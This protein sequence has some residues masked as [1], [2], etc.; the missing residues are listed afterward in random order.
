MPALD[1]AVEKQ[2]A[3]DLKLCQIRHTKGAKSAAMNT[4]QKLDWLAGC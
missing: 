1:N 2:V 3:L 4:A